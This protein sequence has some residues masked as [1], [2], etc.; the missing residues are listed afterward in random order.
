MNENGREWPGKGGNTD[1][2]RFP[3]FYTEGAVLVVER[4]VLL[5]FS[6]VGYGFPHGFK[7]V[8]THKNAFQKAQTQPFCNFIP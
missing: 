8:Q 7:R 6:T 5:S 2:K 4:P 3:A 1:R